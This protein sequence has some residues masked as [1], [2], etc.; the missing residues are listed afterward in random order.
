MLITHAITRTPGMDFAAGLT[1]SGLGEPRLETMLGQHAGYEN[2]LRETGVQIVVLPPLP[3]FPDA[4][5]VEDAAVVLAEIA[6][7]T[8]PG[9]TSRRG[10]TEHLQHTLSD[11]RELLYIEAP[12]TV[13]GGDVLLIGSNAYIGISQRT[14]PA[15]SEQLAAILRHH[16][17]RCT[18]VAVAAGLHLK[19]SV[20]QAADDT[21]LMTEQY[22][23]H[24]A[25]ARYRRITLPPRDA[26]AANV[27]W[28][29]G[30]VIIPAGFP[31]VGRRLEAAG[32]QPRELDVSEVHKM[33]GG[34]TCLSLRF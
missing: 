5:F 4:Y 14:N 11:Y 18:P 29:N 3:G 20:S 13:D 27:L 31:A 33:D 28:L 6:I 8:R 34:L 32:L 9:A 19:S 15:G 2:M 1:S 10:E 17:Y 22:S 23:G 16:G 24:A 25:F 21:L 26:C 7:V 30:R 12:G